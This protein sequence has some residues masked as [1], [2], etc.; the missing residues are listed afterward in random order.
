MVWNTECSPERSV[1]V[2]WLAPAECMCWDCAGASLETGSFEGQALFSGP[3]ARTGWT[4][5]A[6]KLIARCVFWQSCVR[7]VIVCRGSVWRDSAECCATVCEWCVQWRRRQVCLCA[8]GKT[9]LGVQR[10]DVNGE[11]G[12]VLRDVGRFYINTNTMI[13]TMLMEHNGN[14]NIAADTLWYW[15]RASLVCVNA[16][17]VPQKMHRIEVSVIQKFINDFN[18]L[19]TCQVVTFQ[20]PIR[21]RYG[22]CKV[23]M[24]FQVCQYEEWFS[25]SQQCLI[26]L[27][28]DVYWWLDIFA[29]QAL[30]AWQIVLQ[31]GTSTSAATSRTTTKE[32]FQQGIRGS[33]QSGE[34]STVFP[35]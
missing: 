28:I 2:G 15:Y 33:R 13:V 9:V 21:D 16:N 22:V 26:H 27:I 6:E 29:G 18:N 8:T 31:S 3:G 24:V 23:N 4:Y 25:P 17:P 20:Y 1:V 32:W 10:Q 7:L 30:R 19:N 35:I 11:W 14:C 12:T 34:N 5:A